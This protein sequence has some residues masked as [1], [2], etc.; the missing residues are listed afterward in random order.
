MEF[1]FTHEGISAPVRDVA[2]EAI[3]AAAATYA[4]NPGAD[5]EEQLRMQLSSR[6]VRATRGDLITEIA[7]GIRAGHQVNVGRPD[8]SID[9]GISDVAP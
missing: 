2:Q 8:G 5:V 6:G 4:N 7:Q 3:D 1:E 9:A